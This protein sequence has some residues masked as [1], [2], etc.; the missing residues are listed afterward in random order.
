M[1]N[2][3]EL[4]SL[5]L[6]TSRNE[7]L[8]TNT[9]VAIYTLYIRYDRID[10]F[11]LAHLDGSS[12]LG[13]HPPLSSNHTTYYAHLLRLC[14]F[15]GYIA[16]IFGMNLDNATTDRVGSVQP[17]KNAFPLVFA[18][19]FVSIFVGFYLT[20]RYLQI[21]GVLPRRVKGG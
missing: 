11:F 14:S 8:M 9:F 2:A 13:V 5:R 21:T 4:I 18:L 15:A 1:T 6:D 12:P 7:L 16:G 17:A 19:S 20:W 10:E 3:E